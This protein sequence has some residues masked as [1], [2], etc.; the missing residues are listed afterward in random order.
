[1]LYRGAEAVIS[2]QTGKPS[3]ILKERI[4]KNYRLPQIDEKLRRQRTKSEASLLR[5]AARSG[6]YVPKIIEE[7]IFE[8]VLEKIDGPMV[9]SIINKENMRQICEKIGYSIAM[10]HSAG[11]IHGDLTTSNIMM[12]D[13]NIYLID[14]GLGFRSGKAEDMATDLHVLNEALTSTHVFIAEKAWKILLNAYSQNYKRYESCGAASDDSSKK[15]IAS[16]ENLEKRGRYRD[17]SG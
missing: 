5:E 17:R 3:T 8:L 12:K 13:N 14:F 6:V 9:K 2:E 1:M 15:V 4:K 16:L 7:K 11:I 10:L